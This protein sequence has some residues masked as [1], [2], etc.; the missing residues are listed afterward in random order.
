MAVVLRS[1]KEVSPKEEEQKEEH[2]QRKQGTQDDTALGAY[3][4]DTRII[5]AMPRRVESRKEA[6]AV[7]Q[8]H[9]C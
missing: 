2:T 6:S 8:S 5:A 3:S 1:G 9:C 4:A 7:G